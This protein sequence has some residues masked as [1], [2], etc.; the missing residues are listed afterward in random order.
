MTF[1]VQCVGFANDPTL[2]AKVSRLVATGGS[3][4]EV[5]RQILEDGVKACKGI[6]G[7]LAI[8]DHDRGELD[9]RY[10]AGEG[11]TEAK[12]IGRLKVSEETGRGITSH[13]AAT[14][15]PYRSG[16]VL[17]D[18]YYISAFDDVRSEIA[19][20]LVDANNRTRG[21]INIE[22]T[23]FNAFDDQC[24]CALLGLADLATIAVTI[25]DHR[26]REMALVEIGKELSRFSTANEILQKV[27]DVA[28]DAL[29]FED[30]SLFLIDVVTDK[31]VLR[32]S[33][34]RLADQVGKASYELGEGL[35]GWTAL[36]GQPVRVVNP[37]SDP[38]WKGRYEEMPAEEAGAYMAVP[39]R[40]HRGV[41]GVI[42]VQRKKSPYKWFPNDFTE[43]DERVLTTIAAQ[44]GIALDNRR[45]VDQL[46]KAERLAAWGDMSARSAHMIGNRVF[47]IKGDINELEYLLK[48]SKIDPKQALDLMESIKKGIFL[49]EEILNEFREFLKATQLEPKEVDLNELVKEAVEEGFPKRSPTQLK[50]NLAPNLPKI[51]ADPKKLKRCFG[52]IMENSINFQPDGG[53][54]KI[55]TSLADARSKKW[56]KPSQQ[57]GDYV[58]VRFEDTGPGIELEK[59]PKIFNPFYSTRAKG[60]GLGLS[61][62][63]EIVEAHNGGIYENGKPGKGARFT[64]LLPYEKGSSANKTRKNE[65]RETRNEKGN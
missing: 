58:Q 64:I 5:L 31:L 35:T 34:G 56:L 47:A 18:P 51:K 17:N 38:R 1:D 16:N 27:I 29:K 20:P 36:H 32:A 40:I 37:S 53:L 59:K 30:C 14:G 61:I 28:A 65:K 60:M 7:F 24:E 11:W 21:V 43:D 2:F 8:V 54:I 44:L 62:V 57:S 39:I 42:R 63:K 6:R 15:K 41:I 45:L 46:V 4:D 48:Q 13:V 49:L 22:S 50:L 55:T 52:E 12:R 19:V 23:E 3:L 9:V 26:A 33:R 25:A 10:T